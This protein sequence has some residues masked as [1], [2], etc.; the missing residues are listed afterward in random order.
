MDVTWWVRFPCHE[1]NVNLFA[2]FWANS[3]NG[4]W[5]TQYRIGYN[6]EAGFRVKEELGLKLDVTK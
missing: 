3:S 2:I 4:R 6:Y 1:S 5:G